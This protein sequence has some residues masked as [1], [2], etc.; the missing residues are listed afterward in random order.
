LIKKWEE[1]FPEEP[2]VDFSMD[3]CPMLIGVRRKISMTGNS[4]L[5]YESEVL[6]MDDTLVRTNEE[7]DPEILLYQLIVFKEEFVKNEKYFV[8][9]CYL[10]LNIFIISYNS[11]RPISFKKLPPVRN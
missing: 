8:N 3:Q 5:K 1:Y 4:L 2:L 9:I 6:L 7:F 11:R 10:I